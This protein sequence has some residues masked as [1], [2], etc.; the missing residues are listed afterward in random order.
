MVVTSNYK[1]VL[2]ACVPTSMPTIMQCHNQICKQIAI[3][4]MK[5][6]LLG[7]MVYRIIKSKMQQSSSHCCRPKTLKVD[8]SF[9]VV[10]LVDSKNILVDF[11]KPVIQI[12][13]TFN[14]KS[15]E[16]FPAAPQI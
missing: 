6:L 13:V 1:H 12:S 15:W 11:L 14:L 9:P 4:L 2:T 7:A 10:Y 16:L 3:F 5:V 8:W